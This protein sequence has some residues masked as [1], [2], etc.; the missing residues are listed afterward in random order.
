MEKYIF[1]DFDGVLN[2]NDSI[3]Q[4]IHLLPEKVVLVNQI[5]KRTDA[6]IVVSSSWR[7][8]FTAEQLYILLT[9]AGMTVLGHPAAL[10][11]SV[12]ITPMVGMR[13]REIEMWLADNAVTP[14]RYVILDDD[15]DFFA[16]Q[17]QLQIHTDARFGLQPEDVD[18]AV[19]ILNA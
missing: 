17:Q 12:D 16:Y 6:K 10:G 7:R 9:V 18:R 8:I 3:A 15:S 5:A 1:L 4:G 13:G 2:N 19:A 11:Y 14:Y